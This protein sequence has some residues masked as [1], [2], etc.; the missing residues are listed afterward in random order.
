MTSSLS[1]SKPARQRATTRKPRPAPRPGPAYG[2][3]MPFDLTGAPTARELAHGPW[4]QSASCRGRDLEWWFAKPTS[5]RS[6]TAVAL[7]QACPVQRECLAAGLL[8]REEFGVW[9]GVNHLQRRPFLSR[10]IAGESLG[11]VLASALQTGPQET[12]T[13]AA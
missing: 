7:C 3:L 8:Y 10:L 12:R 9:G 13:A 6:R 5:A 4:R 2:I 11:S 1:P